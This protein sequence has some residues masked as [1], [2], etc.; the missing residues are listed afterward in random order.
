MDGHIVCTIGDATENKTLILSTWDS[1]VLKSY[2]VD[3]NKNVHPYQITDND[4][5]F[6]YY[7]VSIKAVCDDED[8][9]NEFSDALTRSN[10]KYTCTFATNDTTNTAVLWYVPG[11]SKPAVP[12]A[13][14]N[15]K[16]F[17]MDV[18]N[19]TTTDAVIGY[20]VIRCEG[21]ATTAGNANVHT[22]TNVTFTITG[23][24]AMS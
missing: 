20:L 21:G 14:G 3:A 17:T 18:K 22:G 13:D 12:T 8:K 16:S 9:F 10:Q 15:T 24:G 2:T 5:C 1:S 11:N 23:E 7:P 6:Q 19:I 4:T